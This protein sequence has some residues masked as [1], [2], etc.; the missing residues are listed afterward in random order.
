MTAMTAFMAEAVMKERKR[1]AR[2][3]AQR[4]ANVTPLASRF[5]MSR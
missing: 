4:S 1:S 5:A 3:A 2:G